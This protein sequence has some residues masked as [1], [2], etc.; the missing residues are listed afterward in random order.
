MTDDSDTPDDADEGQDDDWTDG[1]PDGDAD[2]GED[3]DQQ[4]ADAEGDQQPA[5]EMRSDADG[6]DSAVQAY[7]LKGTLVLLVVLGVVATLQFYLSAQTAIRR[8]ASDE[9]RP[10]FVA[11]FNLVVLLAVGVGVAQV[12]RRLG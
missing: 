11:A 1:L 7:L 9:F 6:D 4:P 3:A 8:F 2:V 12:V 10:V 5:G